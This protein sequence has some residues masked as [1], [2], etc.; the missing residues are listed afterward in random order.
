MNQARKAE[1]SEGDAACN[2]PRV[3]GVAIGEEVQAGQRKS[4]KAAPCGNAVPAR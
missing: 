3:K 1:T 2:R 4:D